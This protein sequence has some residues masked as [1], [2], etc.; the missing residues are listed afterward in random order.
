MLTVLFDHLPM[1]NGI[2]SNSQ[3]HS[4]ELPMLRISS[5]THVTYDPGDLA[6]CWFDSLGGAVDC[7]QLQLC[8][9][10]GVDR[11]PGWRRATLGTHVRVNI[12]THDGWASILRVATCAIIHAVPGTPDSVSSARK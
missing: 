1:S 6:T 8:D 10:A 4:N 3:W 11:R 12:G 7:M 2:S 9:R 5:E